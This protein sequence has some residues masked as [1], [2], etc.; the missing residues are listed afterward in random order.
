MKHMASTRGQGSGTVRPGPRDD[1]GVLAARIVEVARES[2]AQD[3]WAGTTVRGVARAA[4]VDPALVYHYF[5]SKD[6]LLGACTQPPAAF[7]ERVAQVWQSPV[8]ELGARLV[9]TTVRNWDH[10]QD[11]EVIRAIML[12]AA[13]HPPTRERLVAMITGS[14]MGPATIGADDEERE[15]RAGLVASQLLGLGFVRSVWRIEPVASMTEAELVAAVGP[16]IQRYVD[17]PLG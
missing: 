1:R 12:I 2:F 14:L 10:P 11:G 17:G 6:G 13:H 3:G 4:D 5:G 7:L 8:P 15:R 16:T 9:E